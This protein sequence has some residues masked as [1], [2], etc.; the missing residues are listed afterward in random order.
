MDVSLSIVW[1]LV[2]VTF[3][4]KLMHCHHVWGC[5]GIFPV[6]QL[7]DLGVHRWLRILDESL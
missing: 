1:S 5:P 6:N 2:S 4:R 3:S 7:L